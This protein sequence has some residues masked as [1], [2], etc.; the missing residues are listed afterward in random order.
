MPSTVTM[1]FNVA[2][3]DPVELGWFTISGLEASHLE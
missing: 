3:T 1:I 2:I